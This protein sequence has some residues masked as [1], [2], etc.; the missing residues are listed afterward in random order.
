MERGVRARGGRGIPCYAMSTA[1]AN[2]MLRFVE[3]LPRSEKILVQEEILLVLLAG[4][5]RT[6]FDRTG[7][8]FGPVSNDF[9]PSGHSI[10]VC[11]IHTAYFLSDIQFS[12]SISVEDD[13]FADTGF[14]DIVNGEVD[15]MVY[16]DGEVNQ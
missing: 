1:P 2:G 13:V 10:P 11:A 3:A 7:I 8:D 14:G 16:P 12:Q 4:P 15:L 9:E 5:R 6:V